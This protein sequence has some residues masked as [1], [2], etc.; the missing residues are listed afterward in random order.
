MR[1]FSESCETGPAPVDERL[2]DDL[3]AAQAALE[4]GKLFPLPADPAAGFKG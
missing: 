1:P 3:A 2:A 4:Q